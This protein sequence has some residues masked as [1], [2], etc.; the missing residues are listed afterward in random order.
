MAQPPFLLTYYN[1]F[2]DNPQ[3]NSLVSSYLD[4]VKN[5]SLA[6]YSADVVG[7]YLAE[8][9]QTQLAATESVGRA[10]CGEL[11]DGFS[12]L[13][14]Q[15]KQTE[16]RQA[17]QLGEISG[18]IR[19]ISGELQRVFRVLEGVNQRLELVRDEVKTSNVLLENIGELLRIPDSQKQ[20]QHHIELALKFL[21][22]ARKD[23][24]LYQ[25]ALQDLLDAEAYHAAG[26][27]FLQPDLR[28]AKS[29]IVSSDEAAQ[30]I[31][32]IGVNVPILVLPLAHT[33]C[34]PVTQWPSDQLG[35]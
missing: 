14:A 26:I 13:Q 4:Y 8:T 12:N 31:R 20:R 10:I 9:S 33:V 22:N 19:Q 21:K 35:A 25:D 11:Y 23:Q 29:V 1:P 5:T 7:G 15:L 28:R 27:L 6:K 2:S 24:D 34:E 32:D 17:K 3:K 16:L 18:G 30:K